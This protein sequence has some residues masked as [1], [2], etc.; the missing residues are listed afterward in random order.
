M[1]APGRWLPIALALGVV[2]APRVAHAWVE[3][4]VVGDDVR[5]SVERSGAEPTSSAVWRRKS[6]KTFSFPAISSRAR[7]WRQSLKRK[8][9]GPAWHG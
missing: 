7:D 6:E 8:A 9:S 3:A 1:S 2:S 4:H 5:L